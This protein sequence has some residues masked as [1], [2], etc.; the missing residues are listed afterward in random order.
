MNSSR[1]LQVILE[2][3][4]SAAESAHSVVLNST[5]MSLGEA[6]PS[7]LKID[8]KLYAVLCEDD[9]VTLISS[10]SAKVIYVQKIYFDSE[11]DIPREIESDFSSDE[12]FRIDSVKDLKEE[13]RNFDGNLCSIRV[14]V[15]YGDVVHLFS[16]NETWLDKFNQQIG[17]IEQ[18]LPEKEEV[19]T[20][21]E[22]YV[23][24][25]RRRMAE[26]L[27]N[28]PLFGSPKATKM[29]RKLLATD[30]FSDK[31]DHDIQSIVEEAEYIHWSK[32][33]G[34]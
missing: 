17:K 33:Q 32:M 34:G 15:V 26:T 9:I 14:T 10:I 31:S 16:K 30:I 11:K 28:H 12:L 1:S 2:R 29:K 18:N 23:R 5:P 13:W 4:Q 19:E 22:M 21:R 3:V 7:S 6:S 24:Q 25:E 8:V 20:E 27:A